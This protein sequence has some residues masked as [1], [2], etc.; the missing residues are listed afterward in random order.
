MSDGGLHFCVFAELHFHVIRGHY[1]HL[2]SGHIHTRHSKASGLAFFD[3][4]VQIFHGKTQVIDGRTLR[5][6]LRLAFLH[7][8]DNT[9]EGIDFKL[10]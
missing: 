7:N 1:K 10:S 6:A 8:N 4:C 9:R 2:A 3:I 5:A